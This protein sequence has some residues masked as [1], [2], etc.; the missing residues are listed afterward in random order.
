MSIFSGAPIHFNKLWH[1][2]NLIFPSQCPS[3]ANITNSLAYSPFCKECWGKITNIPKIKRC[4]ICGIALPS[5]YSFTCITCL[6]EEPFYKKVYV[7]GNYEG[8][9]KEAIHLMKFERLRRL[10]KP[11]GKLLCSLPLPPVDLIIPVP[12]YKKRLIQRGFNQSHLL[13]H[14]ISRK[15]SIPLMAD[16]L[17][18]VKDTEPQ[19]LLARE[20]RLKNPKGAYSVLN[21][22]QRPVPRS[23]LLVD[24]VMTTGATLNE[25]SRVLL[26]A[27]AEEVYG[28]VMARAK[29]D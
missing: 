16:I 27:G 21:P 11:F 19:S 24:D 18:K 5:D 29:L 22:T 14:Y 10:S 23:V 25:C 2:L 3:C 6:T 7:F 26:N 15:L 20:K 28:V 17:V 8:E 4:H 12:L 9:L 1:I 13:G